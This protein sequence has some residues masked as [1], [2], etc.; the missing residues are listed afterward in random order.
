LAAVDAS[1]PFGHG[2]VSFRCYPHL[3]LDA[4]EIVAEMRAQA[5]LAAEHGFDGVMTSEHHGGFAGYLP[6][7]L[8][9]AGFLLDAMPGGWAAACPVI[10]TLRPAA[11]I[12]EETA[13]LAARHPER[14]GVGLAAGALE[15]DFTVMD[16]D[17]HDLTARFTRAL[18]RVAELLHGETADALAGDPAI[19]RCRAHPIPVVS[20]AASATAV[21]RAAGVGA[22]IILDSLSSV[23]R[24]RDLA[25]AY[26]AAGGVETV[27]LVR[28]VW[29]GD[30]PRARFD[31]QV[32]VY[33]GY[34][35]PRATTTWGHDE[36]LADTDGDALA[37]SVAQTVVDAGA[38]ACNVRIH[39]PGVDPVAARAQIARL[40]QE[41]VPRVREA[42]RAATRGAE[43]S[44]GNRS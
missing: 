25:D 20:A 2:S 31:D 44:S 30:P 43:S 37:A 23:D 28:R 8:Q 5:V 24:C 13:W 6:N 36:L 12:A 38:D 21:R 7:P 41:V 27:V 22:G 18:E 29:I 42:L 26:R 9:L 16:L 11:L 10:A 32:Q 14:V 1:R 3:D 4:P 17:M 40:G 33:R 19:A 35:A 39:V 34:A 15:Q